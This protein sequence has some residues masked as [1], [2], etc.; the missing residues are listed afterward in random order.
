MA[1]RGGIRE[2]FDWALFVTV[3]AIA[4]IGVT[5]LYSATSAAAEGLADIYM[6]QIYWLAL[7]DAFIATPAGRNGA[8]LEH[9]NK[10]K[11]A[12]NVYVDDDQSG[13]VSGKNTR[14][15]VAY[16]CVGTAHT[17]SL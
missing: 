12:V 8:T 2:Q 9:V 14:D 5:N 3:A 4:L 13:C 6:Q 1:I 15:G 17:L 10:G 7:G 16:A 11:K